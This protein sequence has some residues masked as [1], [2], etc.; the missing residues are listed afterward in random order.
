MLKGIKIGKAQFSSKTVNWIINYSDSSRPI[1]FLIKLAQILH[2][3][4]FKKIALEV[5]EVD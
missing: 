2:L 4:A 3:V 1:M 5:I